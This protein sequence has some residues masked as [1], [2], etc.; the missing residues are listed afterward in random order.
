MRQSR[1]GKS[2]QEKLQHQVRKQELFD[3]KEKIYLT[4]E[5]TGSC[6]EEDHP[7]F[8]IKVTKEKPFAVCYYCSKTWIL[9]KE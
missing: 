6:P 4:E 1:Y 3:K 5:W 8:T 9:K 2:L 7:L